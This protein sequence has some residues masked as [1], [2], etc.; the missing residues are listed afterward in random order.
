MIPATIN[1]R[2]Y[3]VLTVGELTMPGDF[4][5]FRKGWCQDVEPPEWIPLQD[6]SVGQLVTEQDPLIARPS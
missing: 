1:G 4:W 3:L 6:Y 2:P 5:L